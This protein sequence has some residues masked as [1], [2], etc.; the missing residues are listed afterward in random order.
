MMRIREN[1]K[2]YGTGNDSID[3]KT[4]IRNWRQE[5]F[6]S[7]YLDV[8]MYDVEDDI[9]KYCQ[10]NGIEFLIDCQWFYCI[11]NRKQYNDIMNL[12]DSILCAREKCW[13]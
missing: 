5:A 1:I 3:R 13:D 11:S 7:I 2:R 6:W 10:S 9:T 4:W 8:D 12:I